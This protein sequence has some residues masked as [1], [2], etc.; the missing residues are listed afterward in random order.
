LQDITIMSQSK[1]RKVDEVNSPA[2]VKQEL[3]GEPEE[4][5]SE[6]TDSKTNTEQ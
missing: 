4:S 5:Q 6:E 3:Q 1:K 2:A